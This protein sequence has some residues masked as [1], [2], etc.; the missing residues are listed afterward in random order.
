MGSQSQTWLGDF[1]F[2]D[3]QNFKI[4]IMINILMLLLL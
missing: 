3:N 2:I 1:H 4:L